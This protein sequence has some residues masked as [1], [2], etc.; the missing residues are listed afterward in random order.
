MD[1]EINLVSI[2]GDIER[3]GM[4]NAMTYKVQEFNG[5]VICVAVGF[6]KF[7]DTEHEQVNVLSN[8]LPAIPGKSEE[9]LDDMIREI[10]LNDEIN[11]TFMDYEDGTYVYMP[12]ANADSSAYEPTMNI[13]NIR[14]K[15]DGTTYNAEILL[16]NEYQQ[17]RYIVINAMKD[18]PLTEVVAEFG[19][20][21]ED[22]ENQDNPWLKDNKIEWFE[23]FDYTGKKIP[24]SGYYLDFYDLIGEPEHVLLTK[25]KLEQ[26]MNSIRVINI[27][28]P[29]QPWEKGDEDEDT[30]Y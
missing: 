5:H 27:I 17:N 23:R 4:P 11:C 13:E 21:L 26:Y 12:Y 10:V 9:E 19:K 14:D 28:V 25:D 15:P 18:M 8:F 22:K 1:K 16:V 6:I 24:Q 29:I 30:Q 7:G 3:F 2:N 20:L